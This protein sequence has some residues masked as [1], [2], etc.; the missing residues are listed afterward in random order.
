VWK[1]NPV[2]TVKDFKLNPIAKENQ[3]SAQILQHLEKIDCKNQEFQK[4]PENFLYLLFRV[5]EPARKDIEYSLEELQKRLEHMFQIMRDNT[6]YVSAPVDSEARKAF[7]SKLAKGFAFLGE[8]IDKEWKVGHLAEQEV[9][10]CVKFVSEGGFACAGRWRQTLE[11]MLKSFSYRLDTG[12]FKESLETNVLSSQMQSVMYK[13]TMVESHRLAKEFLEYSLPTICE[14]NQ[15]HYL[16]FFMRFLKEEKGYP[17]MVTTD[18]DS[19]LEREQ[20]TLEDKIINFLKCVSLDKNIVHRFFPLFQEEVKTNPVLYDEVLQYGKN[21]YRRDENIEKYPDVVQFLAERFFRGETKEMREEAILEMLVGKQFVSEFTREV[22]MVDQLQFH[23]QREDL[24]S[25]EVFLS[26][27]AHEKN[28]NKCLWEKIEGGIGK[29]GSLLLEAVKRGR[30]FLASLLLETGVDIETKDRFGNTSLL[31]ATKNHHED[32]VKMLLSEGANPNLQD[33][34]KNTP[35]I[36]AAICEKLD[37]L[38]MLL[39]NGANMDLRDEFGDTALIYASRN[40]NLEIAEALLRHGANVHLENEEGKTA[41]LYAAKEGHC[42]IAQCLLHQNA[43]INHHDFEGNTALVCASKNGHVEMMLELAKA[44][45]D[46]NKQNKSGMTA[47]MFS[48]RTGNERMLKALL[49]AGA[50]LGMKNCLGK[51]ELQ[52]SKQFG[53]SNILKM[54]KEKQKAM[55]IERMQKGDEH[56]L[57]SGLKRNHQN[58]SL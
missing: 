44:G 57:E 6:A 27:L 49:E 30:L 54:L 3:K 36:T 34:F 35:L 31:L 17:L 20:K 23:V 47:L 55:I 19:F 37:I 13:A 12:A 56:V 39:E 25:L 28:Q 21:L 2:L 42:E 11:E 41:L 38:K 7:F 9:Y 48:I 8:L 5:Q 15:L 52:M 26:T 43:K 58:L 22:S 14:E 45:A 10:D 1:L 50:T 51:N 32:T 46:I 24:D 18:A 29:G 16:T 33:L 40:G 53:R 4:A